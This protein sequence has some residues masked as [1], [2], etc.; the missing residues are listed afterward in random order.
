MPYRYRKVIQ[1]NQ[2]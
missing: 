1:L 2:N